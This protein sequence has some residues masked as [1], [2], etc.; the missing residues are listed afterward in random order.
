[1]P[2]ENHERILIL[3]G[4]AEATAMA[5]RLI[6]EGKQ[7]ISSLAGRTVEPVL[8]PGEV[9]IGGFGGS[10]G[11]ARYLLENHISLVIDATH[12]FASRISQN[13]QLACDSTGVPLK[14]LQRPRW[15]PRG[16]DHWTSVQDLTQAARALPGGARVFLALGRQYLDAFT[17]R[18]DC[19]FVIRMIDPPASPLPFASAELVLGKPSDEEEECALL[20]AHAITHLVCR[21]SGGPAGYGKI[22]AARSLGLPVIMVERAG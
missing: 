5:A 7:V 8:P 1:M 22:A 12:P 4:T 11:L 18:T 9:R 2:R 17:G 15:E 6:A 13:A 21:N 14:A 19:H 16:D 10:E 20:M 3:G